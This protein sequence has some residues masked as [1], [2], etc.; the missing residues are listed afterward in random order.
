M[1]VALAAN[2]PLS[3]ALVGVGIAL[4]G[5]FEGHVLQPFIMGHQVDLHP[6]VVIL[7][8]TGGTLLIGVHR[9]GGRRAGGCRQL[10]GFQCT[11]SAPWRATWTL[12]SQ[13]S[14]PNAR[15]GSAANAR[16]GGVTASL[17]N[18]APPLRNYA[19][20]PRNY[21]LATT[22][23]SLGTEPLTGSLGTY[24]APVMTVA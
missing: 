23:G 18:C 9:C 8:V 22:H 19:P 7:A 11:A 13:T 4:I 3:A 15:T 21:A 12:V 5:Q 20:Q 1:V 16:V 24:L 2:G 17:A 14:S 10:V 6:V